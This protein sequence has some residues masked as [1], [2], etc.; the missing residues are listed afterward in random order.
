MLVHTKRVNTN[1]SIS[2]Y[3]QKFGLTLTI[4]ENYVTKIMFKAYYHPYL[5]IPNSNK[6]PRYQSVFI[7]A[8]LWPV[9]RPLCDSLRNG[10]SYLG[11]CMFLTHYN[12]SFY[13]K[14]LKLI[15]NLNFFLRSSLESYIITH[16]M[17]FYSIFNFF[18]TERGKGINYIKQFVLLIILWPIILRSKYLWHK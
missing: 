1:S 16:L 9:S 2:T 11:P 5:L 13:A 15:F 18:L 8:V 4:N 10:N 17:T 7:N 3:V 6:Q 12:M 14:L